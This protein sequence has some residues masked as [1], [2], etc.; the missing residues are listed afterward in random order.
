MKAFGWTAALGAVLAAGGLL[1]GCGN[2]GGVGGGG[3]TIKAADVKGVWPLTV[4]EIKIECTDDMS[5]FATAND[6]V[7]PLNGQAERLRQDPDKKPVQHL[8]DI[9]KDDPE[10]SRY[11]PGAKMAMDNVLQVAIERC[12]GAGKWTKA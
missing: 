8:E 10:A 1:A 3:M 9:Q 12:Q 6:K 4:D 11:T 5:I 7:Y 2:G